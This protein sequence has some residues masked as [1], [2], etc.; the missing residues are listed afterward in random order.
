MGLY[1]TIENSPKPRATAT[2]KLLMRDSGSGPAATAKAAQQLADEGAQIILGPLVAANVEAASEVTSAAG[3][4]MIAFSNN[5]RVARPDVFVFGYIPYQQ[6]KRRRDFAA[7]QKI[8]HYAAIANQDD[9]GRTVVRDFSNTIASYGYS[10]KPVELFNGGSLPP[11]IVLTRIAKEANEV[12]HE[13][14]AVF[15]PVSP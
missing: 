9:Y 5:I 8:Q 12:G 3:I 6:V 11:S 14:K 2:P 4:P 1:D 15:L 7:Y 13:R 10:V